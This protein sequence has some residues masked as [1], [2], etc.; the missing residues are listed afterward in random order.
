[1]LPRASE[2]PDQIRISHAASGDSYELEVTWLPTASGGL[3]ATTDW[4]LPQNAKLGHYTLSYL[5]QG[6]EVLQSEEG[7]RVEQFKVPFLKGA[8]Q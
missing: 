4:T 2:L 3:G 6:K 7:F 5:R 8:M 1:A